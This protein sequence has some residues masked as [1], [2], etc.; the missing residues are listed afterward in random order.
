[1]AA[2]EIRTEDQLLIPILTADRIRK[3]VEEA[4]SFKFECSEI[5]KQVDRISQMLRSTLRIATSN[6]SVY[7]RP[8]SRVAAEV[9]KTLE[10]TLTLTRKCKRRSILRRVVTIINS[11]DFRKILNLLDASIGDLR[12]L[13]SILEFDGSSG[14]IV[15]SLPPIASN[16]PILAW[17]WSFIASIQMGQLNERIEASNELASLAKDNDR[18]K[19]IIIEEGG[20][21][22]L[23]KVFKE[24]AS[25][26]AQLAAA[27][28]LFNLAN[29]QERVRVVVNENGV[30]LIVQVLT[31]SPIRVQIRVAQLVGRMAEHDP[32]AQEDFAREN[33]IRPLVSLLS[34]EE[35]IDD[36][37]PSTGRPSIHSIVQINKEYEKNSLLSLKHHRPHSS[38]S[39]SLHHRKEREVE[40]PELRHLLKV[41]CAEA[42]W[43]LSRGSVSN[44]R[45]ITE[46]KGLLCLAKLIEK[47]QG[48]LQINCLMTIMTITASAESNADLRRAAFK[49]NSPAAK[50]VVDQLL[51]IINESNSP[52]LQIPAIKAIGSLARTFPA[53]ET[54]VIGPLVTQLSHKDIDLATQAAVSLGKFACPENFLCTQHSKAIIEFNG[55]PPLMRL[56][57][58]GDGTQIHA[59]VLLCYLALHAGNSEALEQSRVLN[60]LEGADRAAAVAHNSELRELVNKAIY[61]LS[62]YHAGVN[63]QRQSYPP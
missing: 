3:A 59:L 57:R 56:L 49:T 39:L 9:A 33:V 37:K 55:I 53:R 21:T 18:N 51:R 35:I 20:V 26:D 28:A 29:D 48:D 11:T 15:L 34:F 62:L 60:A 6:T 43:M 38:S 13:L 7:D 63:P 50:A 25:P 5:A 58:V 12:W 31:D 54:R 47:E 23:L 46:T 45:R 14:G 52:K 61:H 41:C 22:P 44:S 19:T 8:I 16:D 1:M 30:P 36:A 24:A 40:K 10:R 17:V 27:I 32:I 4:D 42:L 2:E